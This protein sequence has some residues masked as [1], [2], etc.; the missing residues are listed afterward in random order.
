MQRMAAIAA[1]DATA[2][3]SPP[4]LREATKPDLLTIAAIAIVA[5][6]ITDFIHEGLGHR[7]CLG[8]KTPNEVFW[9][10]S[11]ALQT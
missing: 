4:S 9:Q 5:T 10:H 2:E 3:S 6:V 7:K 1:K 11:V 8:F